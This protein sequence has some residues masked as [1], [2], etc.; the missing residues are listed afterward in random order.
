MN[1]RAGLLIFALMWMCAV[2]AGIA[3]QNS[4][5]AA[6]GVCLGIAV[7]CF[8]AIQWLLVE[9]AVDT[10][11]ARLEKRLTPGRLN[12]PVERPE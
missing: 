5:G 9:W 3:Y 4:D 2:Q 10:V 12:Q 1:K 11:S 8:L 6:S 7:F